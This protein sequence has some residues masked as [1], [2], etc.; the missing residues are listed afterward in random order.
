MITVNIFNKLNSMIQEEAPFL[1]IVVERNS[2]N[3]DFTYYKIKLQKTKYVDIENHP[4]NTTVELKND[5][6]E[7]LKKEGVSKITRNNN[8]TT[9]WESK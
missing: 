5:I 2:M 6:E 9:F 8:Y 4:L 3:Q 1:R 7:F